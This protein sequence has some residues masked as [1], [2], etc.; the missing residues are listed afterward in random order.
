MSEKQVSDAKKGHPAVDELLACLLIVARAHGEV[1]AA[2]TLMAGLP[3][4]DARLSPALFARA[5][6]RANLAS[7]VVKTPLSTLKPAL[8]PAVALLKDEHACVILG[9][10]EDGESAKVIF[11]ELGESPVDVPLASLEENYLGSSIYA[12]PVHRFDARTPLVSKG[13][14]GHWFWGVIGESRPLYMDVLF[15]ALLANLFALGMPL[16]T[17]NVYDRVVPNHAFET[18]WVLAVGL[19]LMLTG[20]LILRTMRNQFVD[21]ASKRA[22]VKLSAYIMERVLGIRMEQRP[23]SYTHLT[24]PTI[25]SV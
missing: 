12:R 16:F 19:V 1:P 4:E 25:Y 2:D 3:A 17:M 15:A 11:P 23:V 22:D 18:L 13:K 5:A 14:H 8:F 20:D 7:R 9:Y 6:R 21:L 24:L 10:S